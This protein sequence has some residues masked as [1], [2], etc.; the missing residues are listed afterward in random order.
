MATTKATAAARRRARAVGL[1][2][3]ETHDVLTQRQLKVCELVAL[4]VV[5][6]IV[7]ERLQPGDPLIDE[8]KMVVRYRTS[9]A[10][11]REALRLLEV[12]G[13]ISI[14]AGRGHSTVVG[15][16]VPTNLART[17]TLYLHMMGANYDQLL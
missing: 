5:R 6:D 4:E 16:A 15:K 17:M 7:A 1:I 8:A 10:S 2:A 13:L 3:G 14:R 12:Q 9:R 11:L